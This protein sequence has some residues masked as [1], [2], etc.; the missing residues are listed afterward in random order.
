M[1]DEIKP[2][3]PTSNEAQSEPQNSVPVQPE[4]PGN[5]NT[6][7]LVEMTKPSVEEPPKPSE[8]VADRGT[9]AEP[10]PKVELSL[11]TTTVVDKEQSNTISIPIIQSGAESLEKAKELISGI[12]EETRDKHFEQDWVNS[13][14][15]AS[16]SFVPFGV[17]DKRLDAEGASWKQYVEHE[18]VKLR[19]SKPT[20]GSGSESGQKLTG[21]KAIM[22]IRAVTG[23]GSFLQIPL[24]H[25]GIWLLLKTP[26]DS[27]LL[28]LDQRIQHEKSVLGMSTNGLVFSNASAYM[29]DIITSFIIDQVVDST[30]KDSTTEK[31]KSLIRVTDIPLLI[32]G[33][34]STIYP[35]GY[36]F[37]H[38][39]VDDPTVCQHVLHT[40]INIPRLLWTDSTAFTKEQRKH[41]AN[42]KAIYS[43]EEIRAYQDMS[44]W[45]SAKSVNLSDS[46]RA[47]LN[48]PTIKDYVS[49]GYKWISEINATIDGLLDK[50]MSPRERRE[51]VTKQSI[52]TMARQYGHWVSRLVGIENT[53]DG[54]K[55]FIVEDR[56]TMDEIM[57]TLASD[58]TMMDTFVDHVI[59]YIESSTVAVIAIPRIACPSCGKPMSEEYS[60][61]PNLQIL[62][63]DQVFFILRLQRLS[64]TEV[65][66]SQE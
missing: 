57:S 6:V 63:I 35:N 31:L 48:V 50:A 66:N 52:I 38:A 59:K 18:G 8:P 51:Y 10:N 33:I 45:G 30:V 36:P 55:E 9:F 43:E 21:D 56:D 32:W 27:D 34:A 3:V 41:M 22:K 54:P 37:A 11:K 39:C 1:N 15:L 60:K 42:R 19:V 29:M 58:Q 24:W 61:H 65:V 13:V 2:E 12:P 25:S 40:T 17:F 20:V 47:T 26:T 23:M 4:V 44:E 7:P 62:N 16:Y 5:D 64:L 28:L 46:L 14:N 53:D 49:A